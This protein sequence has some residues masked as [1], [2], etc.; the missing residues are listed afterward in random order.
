[1]KAIEPHMH[2][3]IRSGTQKVLVTKITGHGGTPSASDLIKLRVCKCGKTEAYD[4]V[5]TII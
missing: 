2:K 5:R 3:Y 1:M 4:L